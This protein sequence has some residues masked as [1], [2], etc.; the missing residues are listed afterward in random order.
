[1]QCVAAGTVIKHDWEFQTISGIEV[2]EFLAVVK[3]WPNVDDSNEI[4]NLAINNSMIH[5]LSY[6]QGCYAEWEKH[7]PISRVEIARVFFKW[8]GEGSHVDVGMWHGSV[9]Q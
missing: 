6:P 1:L 5:L 9:G 8:R 7:M 3:A 4:T 2:T